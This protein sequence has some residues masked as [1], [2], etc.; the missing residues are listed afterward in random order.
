MHYETKK[1]DNTSCTSGVTRGLTYELLG[2]TPSVIISVVKVKIGAVN[3]TPFCQFAG[4]SKSCKAT[5]CLELYTLSI[6]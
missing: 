3:G 1:A 6:N 2:S 5:T 4:I